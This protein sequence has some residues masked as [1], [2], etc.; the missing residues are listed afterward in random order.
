MR[1]VTEGIR[2]GKVIFRK[3]WKGLAP[4]IFDLPYT[5]TA[6]APNDATE[7]VSMVIY[8]MAFKERKMGYASAV[9]VVFLLVIAVVS[10]VQVVATRKKEVEM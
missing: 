4:S 8:R 5:L 1:I 6:G 2:S 3:I 7:T 10:I 9:S